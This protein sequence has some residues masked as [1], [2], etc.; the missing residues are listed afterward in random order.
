[1]VQF[2]DGKMFY[3]SQNDAAFPVAQTA[4]KKADKAPTDPAQAFSPR[5]A[6][7]AAVKRVATKP[8]IYPADTPIL[9]MRGSWRTGIRRS[10]TVAAV[11]LHLSCLA[12]AIAWSKVCTVDLCDRAFVGRDPEGN[13]TIPDRPDAERACWMDLAVRSTMSAVVHAVECWVEG[14]HLEASVLAEAKQ[15]STLS[16]GAINVNQDQPDQHVKGQKHVDMLLQSYDRA[17]TSTE[18]TGPD[19][20]QRV[21]LRHLDQEKRRQPYKRTYASDSARLQNG[22]SHA[23]SSTSTATAASAGTAT[24]MHQ[25]GMLN[26]R[27]KSGDPPPPSPFLASA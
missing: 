1:M 10:R 18:L 2:V 23:A 22:Q 27:K 6:A 24:G 20:L 8:P 25:P 3:L 9:S 5:S 14:E 12:S 26:V 17:R 11:Q 19:G 16:V 21:S 13:L 4:M 15:K 7:R